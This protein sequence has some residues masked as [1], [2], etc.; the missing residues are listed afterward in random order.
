[1]KKFRWGTSPPKK[2][3]FFAVEKTILRK[4]I[5]EQARLT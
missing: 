3:L 5:S 4:Y 1:M 2:I